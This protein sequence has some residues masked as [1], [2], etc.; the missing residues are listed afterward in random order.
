MTTPSDTVIPAIKEDYE[1]QKDVRGDYRI[2]FRLDSELDT[3]L[4]V[5][6]E[7]V[8]KGKR[9]EVLRKMMH[10]CIEST[11][12]TIRQELTSLNLEAIRS[13]VADEI[14][15]ALKNNQFAQES[16]IVNL[17]QSDMETKYGDK[18][19]LML[20]GFASLRNDQR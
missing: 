14:H 9:S 2:S 7:A 11:I 15:K 3:D 12:P 8:P 5:W 16:S 4:I 19:N 13:V 10:D 18:L 1:H 17:E 20:G 6:L